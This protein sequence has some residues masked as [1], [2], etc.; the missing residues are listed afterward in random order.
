MTKSARLNTYYSQKSRTRLTELNFFP[1][2]HL[3]LDTC[4]DAITFGEK[5]FDRTS[6]NDRTR[7]T[8]SFQQFFLHYSGADATR[9]RWGAK[10]FFNFFYELR[11]SS[12]MQQAVQWLGHVSIC[13]ASIT[14]SLI[15]F[16][17]RVKSLRIGALIEV[18][19]VHLKTL[20]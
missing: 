4:S 12:S 10:K 8:F 2:W 13:S 6:K 5:I 17:G 20:N 3:T 18:D 11:I 1:L 15:Q 9:V 19:F 14:D 7:I 16:R